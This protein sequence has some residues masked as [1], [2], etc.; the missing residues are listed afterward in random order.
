MAETLDTGVA[1]PSDAPRGSARGEGSPVAA[2]SA[3]PLTLWALALFG[4]ALF[5]AAILLWMRHGVS[6]FFD[7]L[8]AGIGSCL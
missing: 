3:T 8:T 1:V 2:P 6:V 7:T 4:G 5:A